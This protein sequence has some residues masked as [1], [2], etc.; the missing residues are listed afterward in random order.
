MGYAVKLIDQGLKDDLVAKYASRANLTHKAEIYGCCLKLLT[1][2]EAMISTWRENFYSMS[3]GVRSHG[4]LIVLDDPEMEQGVMYEPVSSTAFMF[5]VHY[6]GY[7]KSVALA[8][9]GDI[10]EDS[11]GIHSVHGAAIDV[12]GK[13]VAL[14]A[15]S[16]TGKTTHSWGLLRHAEARLVTDDWFFVRLSQKRHLAFA[17]E[18][19]CYVEG[20]IGEVWKE[21]K[22]LVQ[23]AVLDGHERAVL[24]IR[25]I[26][27]TTGVVPMTSLQHVLLL[28]RD[29]KDD[30]VVYHLNTEEAM[31]YLEEND[32]CNPHQLIR[33]ERKLR[34]RRRF[35]EE[36]L[37]RCEVHMVNTT[38]PPQQTQSI[39]RK[40]IG[41]VDIDSYGRTIGSA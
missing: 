21:Y 1:D 13:G 17:S 39:I 16:K 12:A 36:L 40:A 10:L 19:N 9:A 3:E 29:K 11:H 27:G 2:Q 37:R 32:F 15:P 30:R 6:Y 14:V 7:V 34:L 18:K 5:N 26:V 20:D 41:L 24:N 28:K 4:R 38:P 33:D 22:P 23:R 8:I 35:F 31:E 25:W